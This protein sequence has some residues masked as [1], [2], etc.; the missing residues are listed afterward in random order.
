MPEPKRWLDRSS[1]D[2]IR[3][4][5]ESNVASS[6]SKAAEKLFDS[7]GRVLKAMERKE[8]LIHAAR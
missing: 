1:H 6:A 8:E 4:Y 7:Y 2:A 3:C 5:G